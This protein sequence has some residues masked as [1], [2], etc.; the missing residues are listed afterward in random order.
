MSPPGLVDNGG[1]VLGLVAV[2]GAH[3]KG[4]GALHVRVARWLCW[5]DDARNMCAPTTEMPAL[6]SMNE[7]ERLSQAAPL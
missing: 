6:M 5:M 4:V 1:D 7:H 3:D 2:R